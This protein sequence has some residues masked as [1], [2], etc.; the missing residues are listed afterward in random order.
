[1][2]EKKAS[3]QKEAYHCILPNFK[4]ASIV[5]ATYGKTDIAQNKEKHAAPHWSEL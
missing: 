5:C 1:V 4:R 3:L 2:R